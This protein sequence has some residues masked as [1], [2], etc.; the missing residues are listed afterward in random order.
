MQ[1]PARALFVNSGILGQQ[2]L[3][4]F[5]RN[6]Y[7]DCPIERERLPEGVNVHTGQGLA[8]RR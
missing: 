3:A 5:V 2:T 8:G 6:A 4:R 7:T 1:R